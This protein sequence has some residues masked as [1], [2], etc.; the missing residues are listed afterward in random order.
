MRRIVQIFRSGAVRGYP[1][2]LSVLLSSFFTPPSSVHNY[3]LLEIQK[4]SII[5]I[6]Q[7]AG[8]TTHTYSRMTIDL[9]PEEHKRLKAV[10]ALMGVPL[11]DLVLNCLRRHILSENIPNAETLKSFRETE[12]G[13]NLVYFK[14]VED[15]IQTLGL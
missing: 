13:K 11:K 3:G 1:R 5:S 2:F 14:D 10:A 8:M 15:L 7:E 4:Y 12:E 6:G 9:P